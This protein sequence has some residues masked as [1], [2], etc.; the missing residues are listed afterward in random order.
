M[1]NK[2]STSGQREHLPND[3]KEQRQA[4]QYDK[5]VKGLKELLNGDRVRVIPPGTSD[6][7]AVKA[8]VNKQVGPQSYEMITEDGAVYQRNRRHLRKT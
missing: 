4:H 2:W 7:P 6:P 8:S 3:P 5:G 1:V